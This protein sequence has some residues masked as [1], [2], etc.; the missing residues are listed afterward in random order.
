MHLAYLEINPHHCIG[1]N[2][3]GFKNKLLKCCTPG[4]T[5]PIVSLQTGTCRAACLALIQAPELGY[6][7]NSITVFNTPTSVYPK[8]TR[9][10]FSGSAAIFSGT[11][12][13]KIEEDVVR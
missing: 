3:N 13:A 6:L 7:H 11:L 1:E 12:Q 9:L 2:G 10:P 4:V 5:A 8:Y